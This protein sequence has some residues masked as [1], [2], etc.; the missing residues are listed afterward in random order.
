MLYLLSIL[1]VVGNTFAPGLSWWK[2]WGCET[3]N[4]EGIGPS[5]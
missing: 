4:G 3:F 5:C 2:F 1:Y